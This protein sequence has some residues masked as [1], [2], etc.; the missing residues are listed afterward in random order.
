MFEELMR[1]IFNLLLTSSRH[2]GWRCLG[3]LF[4]LTFFFVTD[5]EAIEIEGIE[6]IDSGI[7]SSMILRRVEA[8]KA[9]QTFSYPDTV[10]IIDT[11][12]HIPATLGTAFGVRYKVKGHPKGARVPI[13]VKI[14]SPELKNPNTERTQ[15]MLE[16]ETVRGI[17]DITY[18][19]F[20]F[21]KEWER[22]AG[23]WVIQLFHQNKKLLEE[24]FIVYIPTSGM[25]TSEER[26]FSKASEQ[27]TIQSYLLFT[28][29]YPNSRFKGEAEFRIMDLTFYKNAKIL[30]MVSAYRDY[31]SMYPVGRRIDEAK[32][33]IESLEF[34]FYSKV[35]TLWGYQIFLK[36]Y[37]NGMLFS[38]KDFKDMQG[39]L[40]KLKRPS[41]RVSKHLKGRF[42]D[43][44]V[45]QLDECKPSKS[46]SISLINLLIYE[47]N[48]VVTGKTIYDQHE[49]EEVHTPDCTKRLT[50]NDSEITPP[51]YLDKL[52]L[53]LAFP[54]EISISKGHY[55]E[56]QGKI[57]NL[58][59]HQAKVLDDIRSYENILSD[60]PSGKHWDEVKQRLQYLKAQEA[61]FKNATSLNTI[62]TYEQFIKKHPASPFVDEAMEKSTSLHIKQIFSGNY[63]PLHEIIGIAKGTT[64]K[65]FFKNNTLY[66]ITFYFSGK[67]TFTITFNPQ[68]A[69]AIKLLSGTNETYRLAMRTGEPNESIW[70][71]RVR[72]SG[73]KLMFYDEVLGLWGIVNVNS[74]T[75]KYPDYYIAQNGIQSEKIKAKIGAYN[76]EIDQL[77]RMQVKQENVAYPIKRTYTSKELISLL[78]YGNQNDKKIALLELGHIRDES[79]IKA[80]MELLSNPELGAKTIKGLH[81]EKKAIWPLVAMIKELSDDD[82]LRFPIDY[83]SIFDL[84]YSGFYPEANR[85]GSRPEGLRH[86]AIDALVDIRQGIPEVV[87]EA[88]RYAD[89]PTQIF[90]I[91]LLS[92]VAE[93][94]HEPIL[95]EALKNDD[96]L[97]Q[98]AALLGLINIASEK[99]FDPLLQMLSK[100]NLRFIREAALHGLRNIAKKHDIR[101]K[102]TPND[103]MQYLLLYDDWNYLF[104]KE[105]FFM[106]SISRSMVEDSIFSKIESGDEVQK[107]ILCDYLAIRGDNQDFERLM[108]CL[109]LPEYGD[110]VGILEGLAR[111]RD[112]RAIKPISHL[113]SK[114]VASGVRTRAIHALAEIGSERSIDVLNDKLNALIRWDIKKGV[115]S[116]EDKDIERTI[117]RALAKTK[118]RRAAEILSKLPARSLGGWVWVE[119]TLVKVC[120]TSISYLIKTLNHPNDAYKSLAV[121]CLLSRIDDDRSMHTIFEALRIPNHKIREHALQTLYL[122]KGIDGLVQAMKIPEVPQQMIIGLLKKE[123]SVK[124]A[125]IIVNILNKDLQEGRINYT[126]IWALSEMGREEYLHNM[127]QP[128][129]DRLKEK[130]ILRSVDKYNIFIALG[131]T[132][133]DRVVEPLIAILN[134]PEVFQKGGISDQIVYALGHIGSNKATLPLVGLLTKEIEETPERIFR[135]FNKVRGGTVDVS[136]VIVNTMGKIADPRAADVLI[137]ILQDHRMKLGSQLYVRV[138]N[139]LDKMNGL[140]VDRVLV[141]ELYRIK[142]QPHLLSGIHLTL[143]NAKSSEVVDDLIPLLHDSP[144]QVSNWAVTFLG[145]I[146]N[147]KA[148]EALIKLAVESKNIAA[149][150][151]LERIAEPALDHL[152]AAMDE[153]SGKNLKFL[154][155]LVAKTTNRKA[156]IALMRT[157]EN[158]PELDE[159]ML[160]DLVTKVFFETLKPEY[161]ELFISEEK[162]SEIR[163]RYHPLPRL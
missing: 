134:M 8:G 45:N 24:R 90:L 31:L 19:G 100:E 138:V 46:I 101:V 85:V 97:Y 4:V 145:N 96:D 14:F 117:I 163:E 49:F 91:Y 54:N 72:L 76:E 38:R 13:Q 33:D 143:S 124:A 65:L 74:H 5:V 88:M 119:D 103:F 50:N 82:S 92:K 135:D 106:N 152:L 160:N 104:Q 30:N 20:I 23:E 62:A 40:E 123:R 150:D 81:G 109:N 63:K 99:S 126:A 16:W 61:I 78:Q 25:E 118:S 127:V 162:L 28:S 108:V 79:S 60:F 114:E 18:D 41:D 70:A 98:L 151:Q 17:D 137:T 77:I 2:H 157:S 159:K 141:R 7:S 93:P 26:A 51:L 154:V 58:R 86:L 67:E 129:L 6:I 144:L 115:K 59:F 42:S 133:D 112:E 94:H 146:R 43:K 113:I 37:P 116:G 105:P 68:E 148:V 140:K 89:R 53:Q 130:D 64:A 111:L 52:L 22:V 11:T 47:L 10:E 139:A 34:E 32:S 102:V 125:T 132:G 9:N 15:N 158:N 153:A 149:R 122:R 57:E 155:K 110:K 128:L 107:K 156:V 44:L 21:E 71:A 75:P 83:F 142:N 39:F 84:S 66:P 136:E 87:H 120:E 12:H 36:K 35:N 48:Q 73:K 3:V 1:K 27:D 29:E 131:A 161:P 55:I 121:H 95:I 80:M 56:V 69:G 147:K